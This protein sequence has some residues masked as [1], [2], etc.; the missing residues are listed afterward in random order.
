MAD[1][2]HFHLAP[3]DLDLSALHRFWRDPKP[4]I[5]A[6]EA[7]KADILEKQGDSNTAETLRA[8]VALIKKEAWQKKV[9][10]EARGQHE[11]IGNR[12]E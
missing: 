1:I 6:A 12:S 9:E 3:G 2:N 5:L 4:V 7:L 8:R 10:A 11:V